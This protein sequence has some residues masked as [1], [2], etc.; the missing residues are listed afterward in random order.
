M[1]ILILYKSAIYGALIIHILNRYKLKK[2]KYIG[3]I[4][5]SKDEE[6][7][8]FSLELNGNPEDLIFMK[9]VLFKVEHKD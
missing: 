3:N 7:T 6:K 9:E 4:V 8:I 2:K 1:I 5:V